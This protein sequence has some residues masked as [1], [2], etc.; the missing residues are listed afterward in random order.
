MPIK[1]VPGVGFPAVWPD[2]RIVHDWALDVPNWS[3]SCL[4][5]ILVAAVILTLIA[6]AGRWRRRH[7]PDGSN[8]FATQLLE[9]ED[10]ERKRVAQVIYDGLGHQ[11]LALKNAAAQAREHP[12]ADTALREQL[13]AIS[14]L[15]SQSLEQARGIA[16]RLRPFELDQLGLK[17]ALEALVADV[18]DGTDLRVFKDLEALPDRFAPTQQLH[19]FRL[20]QEA[21]TNV[22]HHA[23]AANVMIE[24]KPSGTDLCLR[25][26]DDGTGFDVHAVQQVPGSGLGL[27][28]MQA[29]ARALGGQLD[30]ASAPGHRTRLCVRMQIR[31][32][33]GE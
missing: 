23:H 28:R 33:Q 25:I 6:I 9:R 4:G 7:S 29:H 18:C 16:Y 21:L 12:A 11:L 14:R 5:T 13:E 20:V 22:V 3:V 31:E 17:T 24:T 15:A 8:D 26:E 19:L 30:I 10:T 1:E 27:A 32:S 2:L